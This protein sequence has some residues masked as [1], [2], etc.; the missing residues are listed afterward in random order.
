MRAEDDSVHGQES[1]RLRPW[2][3]RPTISSLR[4]GYTQRSLWDIEADSSPFY[5]TSYMPEVAIVTESP[6]PVDRASGAT[7]MGVRAGFQ[8]ESN[9]RD[10]DDSR[11]MNRAYFRA[12]F[13][14]GSLRSWYVVMLPEVHAYIGDIGANPLIKDYR[15]YGRLQFYVGRGDYLTLRLN[16]WTGKDF[17]HPS[18]QL[19]LSYPVQLRWLNL[20]SFLQ[21]QYFNGYGESL[22]AYTEKIYAVRFGLGLVR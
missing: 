6:Q 18:Y 7:W 11:S 10:G 3:D 4:L 13:I 19:D 17:N 16:A 1:T 21:V 8:H 5:D 9:G 2:S 15:G 14:L 20:E 22:R 12:R